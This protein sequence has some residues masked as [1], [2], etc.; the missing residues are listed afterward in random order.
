MK[1]KIIFLIIVSLILFSINLIS[2]TSFVLKNRAIVF[3]KV[4]KMKDVALMDK[5]SQRDI[6]ELIISASP[7]IG[8]RILISKKEIYEKLIG[9]GVA[10]PVLRGALSVLVNRKG[11]SVNTKFFKKRI[12]DYIQKYSKWKNGL[13]LKILSTKT[14]IIPESGVKWKI[15]PVNGQDFFGNILFK[16]KAYKGND[17]IFS[18]W[19]VA[20]LKI[21]KKVAIANRII[22]KN[23]LIRE[24]DIRWEEREITLFIKN[25]IF[26]PES[27]IGKRSGRTIRTNTV[28]TTNNLE[29]EYLVKRGYLSSLVAQY[30][31]IRAVADV[32][33]MSNGKYGD[34]VKVLNKH[35]KKILTAMV[36]GQNKMEVKIR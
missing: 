32:I 3:D 22:S 15:I 9:N 23:E 29:S 5:N 10:N 24:D 1:N 13:S 31:S 28:I 26:N 36:V 6:G 25:A 34:L 21:N 27:I 18:D 20:R 14:F 12:L 8:K 35:T 17:E 11:K 2:G 7:N 4:I 33:P 30:K 19:I 16:I